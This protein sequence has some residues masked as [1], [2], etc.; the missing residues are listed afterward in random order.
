MTKK[1]TSATSPTPTPSAC[2]KYPKNVNT[3]NPAK[4]EVPLL[5]AA[6][7]HAFRPHRSVRSQLD[8]YA[9]TD[10]RAVVDWC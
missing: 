2:A 3:T 5:L 8:A 10:T 7:I 9:W 4:S 6:T 1:L